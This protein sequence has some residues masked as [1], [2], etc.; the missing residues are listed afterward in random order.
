[1]ESC[2]TSSSD[3][4]RC[5]NPKIINTKMY[6]HNLYIVQELCKSR[7]GRPG[8]SVLTSLLVSVDVKIY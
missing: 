4:Q 5:M 8:L 2:V 3:R 6:L 7:G 1:M